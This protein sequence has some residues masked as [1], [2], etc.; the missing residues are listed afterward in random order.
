MKS[1]NFKKK[2]HPAIT[3]K[4]YPQ[5]PPT[6]I[7]KFSQ[8]ISSMKHKKG[9][10]SN[11]SYINHT[12]ISS[13]SPSELKSPSKYLRSENAEEKSVTSRQNKLDQCR[14]TFSLLPRII[15]NEHFNMK[16]TLDFFTNS[17]AL[18]K[19]D[20]NMSTPENQLIYKH[21]NMEYVINMMKIRQAHYERRTKRKVGQMYVSELWDQSHFKQIMVNSKL[22]RKA[23]EIDSMKYQSPLT[24]YENF[25]GLF[26]KTRHEKSKVF[27]STDDFFPNMK[28]V[29]DEFYNWER[30][31]NSL[32]TLSFSKDVTKNLYYIINFLKKF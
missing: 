18:L 29:L 31:R 12:E 13:F 27:E 9:Q 6:S 28:G 20:A 3:V 8:S 25:K 16:N 23:R 24:T 15:K 14:N 10:K 5:S 17:R 32:N 7:S 26:Y 2:D 30:G 19:E 1:L 4:I 11:P 22:L 21:D